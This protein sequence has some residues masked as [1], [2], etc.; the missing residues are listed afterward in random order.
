M[1]DHTT[2]YSK[3]ASVYPG[4]YE[5][6][7]WQ[8]K[9][10]QDEINRKGARVIKP[11]VNISEMADFYKVEMA[12]PGF[13]SE[14]FIIYT[15]GRTLSIAA[16]NKKPVRQ[17]EEHYCVHNFNCECIH[18]NLTLPAD[19]DT[20]FA[21]AEYRNGILELYFYKTTFPTLNP[22]GRIIVY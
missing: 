7:P 16:L 17:Q 15:N 3:H 18:R 8:E 20:N 2:Y 9:E 13:R 4:K 12:A 21:T 11:P 10:L 14:D 22:P 19:T 5:P 6:L 1:A